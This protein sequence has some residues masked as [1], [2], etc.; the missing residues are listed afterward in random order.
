MYIK[1]RYILI[2]T[3]FTFMLGTSFGF[4]LG[5]IKGHK[6]GFK[7]GSQMRQEMEDIIQKMEYQMDIM[8]LDY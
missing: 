6:E 7:E 3:I 5:R 4:Y 8:D 2:T 1:Y